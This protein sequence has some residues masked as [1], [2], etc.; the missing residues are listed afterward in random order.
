ML[1]SQY[2]LLL[3]FLAAP[4]FAAPSDALAQW[5]PNGWKVITNNAGD[6]NR[7]G[8][9]DVVLVTEETNPANFKKKPEGSP[10]PNIL[11]LNPRRLVIL[12]RSSSGLK[13]VLR[14]DNLLPSENAEDMDCLADPLANGGVSIARGNL[15]IE[16]QDW[17]SCGSYGVVS[18]KFTFRTQGTR[19][20]LVGY[21]RSES[22]RSTG[23]RSEYSTNYLTGKKKTTTGL[24]DFRDFKAE[25][26]WKRLPSKKAFFLDEISL[27][28][29]AA[30]PAQKNNWCQ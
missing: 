3:A 7:D 24:N 28:C 11:N 25:V 27:H 22:S 14:R 29:D 21:D 6:L 18:E 1:R 4:S 17:R 15:V 30:D 5:V 20:Q 19:F 12:L 13:E 26:S 2:L 23:E 16:L 10:G 8:I 9:D